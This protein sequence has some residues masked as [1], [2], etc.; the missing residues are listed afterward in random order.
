MHETTLP[1]AMNSSILSINVQCIQLRQSHQR[2]WGIDRRRIPK[3]RKCSFVYINL[4]SLTNFS[5]QSPLLP[6]PILY[7]LCW[8]SVILLVLVYLLFIL[9]YSLCLPLSLSLSL[10]LHI[11]VYLDGKGE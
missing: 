4:S 2:S 9:V 5:L 11:C 8:Q 1:E 7:F 3:I 6:P 10:I